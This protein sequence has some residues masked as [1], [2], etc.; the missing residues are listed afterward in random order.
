MTRFRSS[1]FCF[2]LFSGE[3]NDSKKASPSRPTSIQETSQL[4]LSTA[5][6]SQAVNQ[7][8][9]QVNPVQ[10]YI[11]NQPYFNRFA[12]KGA[13]SQSIN[14][15]T[16]TLAPS[17]TP[18]VA[19]FRA[20]PKWIFSGNNRLYLMTK[21]R[22]EK[23]F[24]MRQ[25]ENKK[26]LGTIPLST[27]ENIPILKSYKG[28]GV[29]LAISRSNAYLLHNKIFPFANSNILHQN[30]KDGS[31]LLYSKPFTQN[32]I[33]ANPILPPS[34]KEQVHS[35]TLRPV[36]TG[37]VRNKFMSVLQPT[38]VL[39]DNRGSYKNRTTITTSPS[40]VNGY[41]RDSNFFHDGNTHNS[42]NLETGH[43][44]PNPYPSYLRTSTIPKNNFQ[45]IP[46]SLYRPVS[47]KLANDPAFRSPL[48]NRFYP[49]PL[50]GKG[51]KTYSV[52]DKVVTEG[53]LKEK[54]L[55]SDILSRDNIRHKPVKVGKGEITRNKT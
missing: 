5:P 26:M 32:R 44:L 12:G 6:I 45:I 22:K 16:F 13:V 53:E 10:S 28:T 23:H 25:M 2:W 51:G 43:A 55:L 35:L 40:L 8:T 54:G 30:D 19:A 38:G 49:S 52:E 11:A 47:T 3:I 27:L 39:A 36:E 17:L 50:W 18:A 9:F 48:N 41:L 4:T 21:G 34:R 7:A 1:S 46:E 31:T 37:T 20:A 14:P 33:L 42:V 29:R 24:S 15:P